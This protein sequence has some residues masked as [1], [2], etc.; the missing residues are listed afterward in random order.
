MNIIKPGMVMHTSNFSTW[1]N[2]AGESQGQSP[3][4]AHKPAAIIHGKWDS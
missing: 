3:M 4:A 1:E 2:N